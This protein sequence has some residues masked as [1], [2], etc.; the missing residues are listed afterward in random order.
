MADTDTVEGLC[1]TT[2]C[3]TILSLYNDTDYCS[4]CRERIRS[5]AGRLFLDEVPLFKKPSPA[6]TTTVR[7]R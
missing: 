4:P 5:E 2:G 6:R 3:N 7:K 1:A